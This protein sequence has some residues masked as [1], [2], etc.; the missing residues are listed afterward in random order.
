[1][2]RQSDS[3]EPWIT[4]NV[5]MPYLVFPLDVPSDLSICEI[6]DVMDVAGFRVTDIFDCRAFSLSDENDVIVC[7]KNNSASIII[8]IKAAIPIDDLDFNTDPIC[9]RAFQTLKKLNSM[10]NLISPIRR[11]KISRVDPLEVSRRSS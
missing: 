5:R 2:T 3:A 6:V 4:T 9:G 7:V 1:M 8:F 11:L 10:L